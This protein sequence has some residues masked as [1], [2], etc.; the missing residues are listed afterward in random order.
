MIEEVLAGCA[1]CNHWARLSEK[2]D[3]GFCKR[4]PPTIR[5]SDGLGKFIR[6]KEDDLCGEYPF[7]KT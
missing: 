3:R 4:N 5:G 7:K 1:S 2:S 6:T